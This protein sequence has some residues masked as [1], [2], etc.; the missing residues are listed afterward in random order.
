MLPASLLQLAFGLRQLLAART[1]R[2]G[3]LAARTRVIRH[4]GERFVDVG[5]DLPG[6]QQNPHAGMQTRPSCHDGGARRT[7]DAPRD[8]SR[9]AE[10]RAGPRGRL[11]AATFQVGTIG[12]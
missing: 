5:G 3:V 1:N 4:A 12:C 8:L 10:I 2:P 7:S 11:L 6:L 9:I